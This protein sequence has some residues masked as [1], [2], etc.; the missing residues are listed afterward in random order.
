MLFIYEAFNKNGATV[1][2]EIDVASEKDVVLYL[3]SKELIPSRIR[4]KGS[5]KKA[6]GILSTELFA[7]IKDVDRIFMVRNL[8][9]AIKAG[10]S[11]NEALNILINDSKP[12]LLHDILVTAKSTVQAGRPLSEALALHSKYFPPI[13]IGL[14]KAGE[15]SSQLDRTLEEL[16]Q[17]L[18]KEYNL[19]R[20]IK[21]ALTY[22]ILLLI[23]SFGVV[24]F[25]L[26]FVLPRLAKTFAL[27]GAE[28][29]LITKILVG[30]SKLLSD[31]TTLT[32]AVVVS[33]VGVIVYALKTQRGRKVF[34]RILFK[35][36]VVR[37][38]IQK[39]AL[40]R[41]TRTLESLFAGTTP[42]LKA[43]EISAEA[44]SSTKPRL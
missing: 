39:V 9:T 16:S 37:D 13:F 26:L 14:L 3:E 25:L 1:Q 17:Y 30:A 5:S 20:K 38:L 43:L 21:S 12:G 18:V 19:I 31:H 23:G 41:F 34:H 32:L 8:A 44:T 7:S 42:V 4:T 35:T 33:A 24:L 2:G 11:M 27:S 29:P 15:A 28:L 36:P 10:L 40:V 6:L 22:P